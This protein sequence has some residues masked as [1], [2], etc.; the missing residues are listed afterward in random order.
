MSAKRRAWLT[1][2]AAV[3]G[4][5]SVV[6]YAVAGPLDGTAGT[7]PSAAGAQRPVAVHDMALTSAAG[8]RPAL[9]RTRTAPFSLLGVSW[10]DAAARLDGTAQVRT[11]D[12]ATGR[13]S[14]WRALRPSTA[15]P[16][17]TRGVSEPLW[18]GPSDGVEARVVT[19]GGSRAGLPR[20]LRVD[21]V[22]PGTT[23]GAAGHTAATAGARGTTGVGGMRNAA[24]VT[25]DPPVAVT[26]TVTRPPIVGRARWGANE[27][28]VTGSPRYDDKVSAVFVHHTG[29]S[30]AYSC[31]ESPAL[32]RALMA[33]DT[34]TAG[35]GDLRYNFV[36]DKCGRI[37]EGRAGGA[38]LPVRGAHT[39]GFDRASTGVA[40]LGDYDGA[41]P[42]RAA[43]ESVARLAAWKLG[44][45]G[46]DP[47][48][49]V[50][51]TA[52][53]DN[54]TY[55]PDEPAELPVISGGKDA[56][57]TASPG[58]NLYA[59]LPEIRRYAASPARNSAIPTADYTGDGVSDLVAATP[60]TGSGVITLVPGGTGG[61]VSS[62]RLRLDQ[63]SAGV[64]GA[65]ESGDQWGSAT[66]WGDI[67]GDGYADLAVGAPGEDDTTG[68]ADRG[69]VTILYG[70]SFTADADT[71][72]LG[73]DYEPKGARFG[74][75]VAV[76]DFN[77]DGRADVFTAAT[78]TGGNWAA[79]FGDGHEVA[80]DLTTAT[81]PLAYADAA[82]G[83]FNRDGYADVVLNYRDASGIGKVT[84]F[85]GSRSLGLTK[86]ATLTV[87]G[88][89]AVAAGDVDGNGYD[90]IVVGQPYTGE[91]GGDAGGQITMVPGSATGPT[92]TG[93]RTVHQGTANVEGASEASD[94]FG[95]SV[96]VG[97]VDADGH[98]DVLTGAPNEDIT[99]AGT[100]RANAGSVWLL[101][102][103]A[104]GPTGTGSLALSQDAPDVPGSTEKDDKLGSAVSL[105]DVTGDG[106]ADLLIGAEGE[107]AGTGTILYVPS[108]GGT[109]TTTKST[110]YGVTQLGTAAG[111]RLGQRVTP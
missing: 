94:G 21:L 85:K 107:D 86:V 109:P 37:H 81:G 34:G 92:T 89:R 44:Q 97:D 99:R 12:A 8:G 13:W 66:A 59:E 52:S 40:V 101:K 29:G 61:P 84:W 38:D 30:D 74:A 70:P 25:D 5:A 55:G 43:V 53:E 106:H 15:P 39:P 45:Y 60:G 4:G 88:G 108:P 1:L 71:M 33:Y 7:A 64:P 49:T 22:D 93:V 95:A 67:N 98:A 90:D 83:D 9:A 36:V 26:S 14:A 105:T 72:A 79:R 41:T 110:Y 63:A 65:A 76:G 62:A 77:A 68:H 17:G 46:G 32:I 80:G 10:T 103:T 78:G 24:F 6:S 19:A 50:T 16:G 75:T 111:A 35:L 69:A 27:A 54:G 91:S 96:S 11:R 102:G 56:L 51:L 100:N 31:A 47:N 3:A 48:G 2:G 42:T 87:K 23:D 104:S 18:V 57:S 82:S 28:T 20:G 58:A 73:D